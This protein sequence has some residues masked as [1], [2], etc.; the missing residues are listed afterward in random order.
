MPFFE[1]KHHLHYPIGKFLEL[2]HIF[3]I[4]L[5]LFFPH[6]FQTKRSTE[7]SSD[8]TLFST[9]GIKKLLFIY[10]ISNVIMSAKHDQQ[11]ETF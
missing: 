6:I 4:Y 3:E 2:Y 8:K 1:P 9:Q 5:Y 10:K 11:T 7:P